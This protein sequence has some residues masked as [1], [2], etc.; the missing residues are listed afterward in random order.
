M[1]C[2][3]AADKNVVS[4]KK[5]K[6]LFMFHLHSQGFKHQVFSLLFCAVSDRS[7]KISAVDFYVLI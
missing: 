6:K 7:N 1:K 3:F 2:F 4:L 5:K